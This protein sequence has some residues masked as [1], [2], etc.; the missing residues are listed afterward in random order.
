MRPRMEREY[1][2]RSLYT[3]HTFEV[4][5]VFGLD[6]RSFVFVLV[7]TFSFHVSTMRFFF[8]EPFELIT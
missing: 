8:A 1:L 3:C 7:P 4:Q 5:R 2:S 6:G